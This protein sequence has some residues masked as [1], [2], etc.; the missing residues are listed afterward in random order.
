MP[1]HL[2]TR[3][4]VSTAVMCRHLNRKEQTARGW[5]SAE[6][7]PDG[8]R[9]LRVNSRLAWPVAGIRKVLGVAK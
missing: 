9:P 6:T 3:T 4:H 7:F 2:E 8:L 1:L 5:A